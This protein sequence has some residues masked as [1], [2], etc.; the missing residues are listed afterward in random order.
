MTEQIRMAQTKCNKDIDQ[1]QIRKILVGMRMH[2]FCCYGYSIKVSLIKKITNLKF[3]KKSKRKIGTLVA[4]VRMRLC[5][6]SY[7]GDI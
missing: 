1:K 6:F 4:Y 7:K 5:Y 3:K 2:E